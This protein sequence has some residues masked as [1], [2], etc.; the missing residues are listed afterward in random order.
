MILHS[1]YNLVTVYNL[2]PSIQSIGGLLHVFVSRAQFANVGI[3]AKNFKLCWFGLPD[4]RSR[5][6]HNFD[7]PPTS[8]VARESNRCAQFAIAPTPRDLL[9]ERATAESPDTAPEARTFGTAVHL[10]LYV[11]M[12]DRPRVDESLLVSEVCEACCNSGKAHRIRR[13][14]NAPLAIGS[15]I[16]A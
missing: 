5:T 3:R 9:L 16:V 8:C 2:S 14:E 7:A 12:L 6:A 13:G 15:P 4:P 1:K 11:S 10:R